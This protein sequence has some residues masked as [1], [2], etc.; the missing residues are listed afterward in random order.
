VFI[1]SVLSI[2][3]FF[4]SG[5]GD[6]SIA[7]LLHGWVSLFITTIEEGHMTCTILS[8]GMCLLFW[9]G[10]LKASTTFESGIKI[11][12][13]DGCTTRFWIDHWV[14]NDILASLYPIL[15]TLAGD[16]YSTIN[17]Q[18]YLCDGN[19]IWAPYFRWPFQF[20]GAN[21]SFELYALLALLQTKCLSNSKDVRQWKLNKSGLFTVNSLYQKF[22][23][24]QERN[25]YFRWI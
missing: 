14:G 11:I 9:G 5:G 16:P 1:I 24:Y 17:S 10:F 4:S 21:L 23:E 20:L 7:H 25:N 18:Y 15:F 6:S 3:F 2:L 13:G 8:A 12:D 22:S 19:M